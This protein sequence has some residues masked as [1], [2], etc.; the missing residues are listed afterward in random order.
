MAAIMI[1]TRYDS[2]KFRNA[3]G[4]VPVIKVERVNSIQLSV[5]LTGTKESNGFSIGTPV[6]YSKSTVSFDGKVIN[7]QEGIGG[8]AEG[9]PFTVLNIE[10]GSNVDTN[11]FHNIYDGTIEVVT[12][13]QSK[14][15]APATVAPKGTYLKIGIAFGVMLIAIYL[16]NRSL[17]K[18]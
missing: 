12:A 15:M 9:Q 5:F 4:A 2:A 13:M 8:F 10:V 17:K 16:F 1:N 11:A 14:E 3:S 18:G 6:R 7:V